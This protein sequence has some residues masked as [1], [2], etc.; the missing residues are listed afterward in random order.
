MSAPSR[1]SANPAGGPGETDFGANEWLVEEQYEHYLE[2]KDSVSQEWRELFKNYSPDSSNG[3]ASAEH[4]APA[5]KQAA[6]KSESRAD[7]GGQKA[8]D[9]SS[10]GAKD[11]SASGP[12]P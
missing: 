5:T 3:H 9:S 10:G 1:K 8:A 4:A 11:A 12:K 7:S 2:D 6:T